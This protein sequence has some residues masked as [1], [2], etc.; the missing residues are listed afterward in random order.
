MDI[1]VPQIIFQI[2]NFG[3]VAVGLTFLLLKPVKKMLDDRS[4]KIE[5]GQKAAEM[6]LAEKHQIDEMK[7]K[8]Q[9][10]AEREAAKLIEEATKVAAA[11]RVELIK[12]YKEEAEKEVEKMKQNVLDE[13]NVMVEE[14]KSKF[15]STVLTTVEKLIG[16][17]DKKASDKIINAELS[18]LLERI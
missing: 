10:E 13:K 3:A 14:M 15:N 17:S 9:K 16:S 8:A 7:K 18:Q 1:Q 12:K 2:I 4:A 11:R 5:E 6:S